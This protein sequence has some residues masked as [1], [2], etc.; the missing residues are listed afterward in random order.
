[1]YIINYNFIVVRRRRDQRNQHSQT[2]GIQSYDTG[3]QGRKAR[4]DPNQVDQPLLQKHSG[5][6]EI[7][8]R[9]ERVEHCRL[10][11]EGE[12]QYPRRQGRSPYD[13]HGGACAAGIRVAFGKRPPRHPVPQSAGESSGQPQPIS[14][15]HK[16][17]GWKTGHCT[18]R[19]GHRKTYLRGVHGR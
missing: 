9:T 19:G 15:I 1:M 6:P 11:R 14:R 8:A 3:C 18:G 17:R 7:Y 5:L 13:H 4:P 16:G 2:R 10:F 12:H